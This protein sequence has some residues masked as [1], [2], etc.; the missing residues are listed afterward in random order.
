MNKTLLPLILLVTA[1][2]TSSPAFAEVQGG[3][4]TFS[5]FVGAYTFDGVQH[6]QTNVSTGLRYGY[7]LDEHWAGE[8]QFTYVPLETTNAAITGKG[9]LYGVGANLLYHFMPKNRLVPFVVLG[10]NWLS[11]TVAG[12][13]ESDRASLD[14][15]VGLKYFL[16]DFVALRVD[17]RHIFSFHRSHPLTGSVDYWQNAEYNAGLSFQFGAPPPATPVLK[18][19]APAPEPVEMKPAPAPEPVEM[20]PAPAP[21]P[22]PAHGPDEMLLPGRLPSPPSAP[23]APAPEPA[24][25]PAPA[26][27]GPNSWQAE[28]TVA[29][30]G[31]ILVTGFRIVQNSLEIRATQRFY[32]QIYTLAQP[33]RLVI[34]INN[35]L[36][37][38]RDNRIDINKIGISALRLEDNPDFL[39]IILDAAQENLLPYRIEELEKGLKVIVTTPKP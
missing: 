12:H 30:E 11:S 9:E 2:L 4:F 29:P 24:P 38:F 25:A 6:L 8:V 16:N 31:K 18:A 19:E 36:N 21:A 39:R 5:P 23:P 33:S 26:W 14:Y 13:T 15:G 22:P 34:D 3:A 7:N 20:K 35:G 32:Y 17:A 28:K 1:F 10:G 37:G 27:E